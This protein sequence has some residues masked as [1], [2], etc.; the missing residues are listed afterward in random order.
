MSND[1]VS[2]RPFALTLDETSV[3]GRVD[4]QLNP[5]N[6]DLEL[7]AD[8]L[9]LDHYI[10]TE[11]DANSGQSDLSP[12][13]LG[14]YKV[15]V[16]SLIV[17]QH[18]LTDVGVDLGIGADEVTLGRLDANLFGGKLRAAG[19]HLIAPQITNLTGTV[20]GIQLSQFQ[21]AKPWTP[22]PDHYRQPLT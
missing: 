2:L 1:L 6:I 4:L 7:L 15:D 21:F 13:L 20:N 3:D 16:G 10:T 5:L 18:E 8:T 22:Y 9:N 14:T 17:N 11:S 19:T 12:V